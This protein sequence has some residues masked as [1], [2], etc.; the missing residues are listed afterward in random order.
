M[1]H[2][3]NAMEGA[4][5]AAAL[6]RRLLSFARSE[7]LL[8]ERVDSAALVGGMGELLDRTLGERIEVRTVLDQQA[9]PVFVDAHQLENAILNLAVNGR[10]A[11]DGEGP[12]DDLDRQRDAR[13][14]CRRRH[15]AGRISADFG[16]R[17]RLRDDA[18]K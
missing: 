9:W 2:L 17:H 14:Q 12:V 15:P 10:D 3:T 7:P 13:R 1:V 5:R 4:T 6:T 11:M 8:P 16:H 18:R